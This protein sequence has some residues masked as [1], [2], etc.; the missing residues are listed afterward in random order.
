MQET[1]LEQLP[2]KTRELFEKSSAA[3]ERGNLDYARDMLKQVM[4]TA[5]NFLAAR[6][7]FHVAIVKQAL[8]KKPTAM[9]HQLSSLKGTFTLMGA[10][11]K[12]KKNPAQ[13]LEAAEKLLEYRQNGGSKIGSFY[14]FINH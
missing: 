3:I 10:Q 4:A 13:A 7:N 9:T 12:L 2:R 8:A 6:K 5:P 14:I 1:K 11:G